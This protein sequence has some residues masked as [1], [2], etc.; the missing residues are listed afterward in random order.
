MH[1]TLTRMTDRLP[2]PLEPKQRQPP[3]DGAGG[4]ATNHVAEVVKTLQAE[5]A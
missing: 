2:Y 3:G 4:A 5:E 1:M